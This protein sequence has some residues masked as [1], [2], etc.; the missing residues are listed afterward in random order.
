MPNDSRSCATLTALTV[1]SSQPVRILAVTGK[2]ATALT[3]ASA[4]LPNVGQSLSRAEPPFFA[5][6]LFTGQ[7]K[8]RSMKSGCTHSTTGSRGLRHVFRVATEKLDTDRSFD[9]VEVEVAAGPGIAPEDAFR[10]D[11]L[12]H[13]N[14][15]AVLLAELPENFIRDAGHRGE[16]ERETPVGKPGKH[17]RDQMTNFK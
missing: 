8:F 6:T 14:I 9:F 10:G 7:P 5:T 3:T 12:C 1:A 2:G 17:G 16:V 15:G 4:T 11:E 13:Q